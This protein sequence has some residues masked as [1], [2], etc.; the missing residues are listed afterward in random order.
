MRTRVAWIAALSLMA[1]GCGSRTAVSSLSAVVPSSSTSTSSAAADVCVDPNPVVPAPVSPAIPGSAADGAMSLAWSLDGGQAIVAPAGDA[2]PAVD[3]QRALCT[4]LAAQDISHFDVLGSDL[5]FSLVLGKVTI[6][7]HLLASPE[8]VGM[9]MGVQ[10]PPPLTPF[11]SRLAWVGVIN[12]PM[13]STCGADGFAAASP[14]PPLVPY[15]LLVLDAATGADGL[16]YETRYYS[17]CTGSPAF[18]PEVSTL[19]VNVSVPWRLMSRDPGGLLG[20]IDLSVN[21][22]DGYGGG[23]N[24]SSAHL[25]ELEFD[26]SQPIAP[27]GSP[28]GSYQTVRGPTVSDP[29]PLTLTHAPLGYRDATPDADTGTVDPAALLCE[30]S[31]RDGEDL[32]ADYPTTIEELLSQRA[33]PPPGHVLVNS[34]ANRFPATAQAAWC[35]AKS[36]SGYAIDIVGPDGTHLSNDIFTS[37]TFIDLAGGPPALP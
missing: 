32:A 25:G 6:A 17:P 37:T 28:H 33:G 5:G 4:L 1:A 11:H 22:C 27:C 35:E 12:D 29:L 21:S 20:T 26:V 9:E 24:T 19:T 34:D 14:S 18:G 30:E 15:Q 31:L 13:R 36:V 2:H 10:S 7:D 8:D 16:V 3:R 23:A